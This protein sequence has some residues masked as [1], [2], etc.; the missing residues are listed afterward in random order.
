MNGAN[1]AQAVIFAKFDSFYVID[2]S[3]ENMGL[4]LRRRG[5]PYGESLKALSPL[6]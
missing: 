6:V 1:D 3:D 4:K 5:P 2:T